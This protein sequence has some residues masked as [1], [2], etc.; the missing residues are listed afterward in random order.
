MIADMDRTDTFVVARN[1]DPRSSLPYL[2]RLPVDGGLVLKAREPWPRSSRVYCHPA[3]AW[4]EDAEV[5]E[6]VPVRVCRRRGSAIDLVLARGRNNRAQFV[7]TE[8]RTRPAIFWQTAKVTRQ[9]RPGVRVPSRW[10]SGLERL[11][12]LVDTRERY[13]YRFAGRPVE[14]V[15]GGLTAG[16]YGAPA[17]APVAAVE[18]KSTADLVKGLV[19]G[20]L[21]FVMGELSAL[22]AAA[23][24]VEGRYSE[25]FRAERVSPGWLP[26]LLARLQVRYPGVPVVFAET[27]KLAE[28]WTYRFL[29]AAVRE[30]AP[31]PGSGPAPPPRASRATSSA[32]WTWP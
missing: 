27:R 3:E 5:L 11:T 7:F 25:L 18:R 24:V 29:A 19:E 8:V 10:A 14:T 17:D 1:P 28:E 23:V 9:A 22:P 16:D 13:P 15:R 2:L 32:P 21:G 4:P 30:F 31:E 6:E 26:E 20:S 12:V